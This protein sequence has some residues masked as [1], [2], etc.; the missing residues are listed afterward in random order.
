MTTY[1]VKSYEK[2]SSS[3]VYEKGLRREA[4]DIDERH[5]LI[6]SFH[7]PDL[8]MEVRCQSRISSFNVIDVS[9][10]GISVRSLFFPTTEFKESVFVFFLNLL[11]NVKLFKHSLHRSF[12]YETVRYWRV[13]LTSLILNDI[14]ME[15]AHELHPRRRLT[16]STGVSYLFDIFDEIYGGVEISYSETGFVRQYAIRGMLWGIWIT[17]SWLELL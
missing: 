12:S 10:L 13:N 7:N 15:I 3:Y 9:G 14:I 6:E 17:S 16:T 5:Y 2:S 1:C 4:D 8:G 11:V